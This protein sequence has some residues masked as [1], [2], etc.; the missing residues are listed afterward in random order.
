MHNNLCSVSLQLT[1]DKLGFYTVL[2][3]P[4]LLIYKMI[5]PTRKYKHVSLCLWSLT[6]VNLLSALNEL[7]TKI[8]RHCLCLG[9]FNGNKP[10]TVCLFCASG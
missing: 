5:F 10:A 4:R 9:V 3:Y 2:I 8:M 7:N 6:F 1:E